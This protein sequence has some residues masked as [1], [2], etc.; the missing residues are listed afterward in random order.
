MNRGL[1]IF[2]SVYEKMFKALM[3]WFVVEKALYLLKLTQGKI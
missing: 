3:I 2:V 1:F